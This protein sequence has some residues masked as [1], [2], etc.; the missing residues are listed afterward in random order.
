MSVIISN[1]K[2]RVT[3]GK[4][5]VYDDK[6]AYI[7]TFKVQVKVW[8]FWITIKEFRELE[9]DDDFKFCRNEAIELYHKIVNPYGKI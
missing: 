6:P 5:G 2:Y 3:I 7:V 8:F 4:C 1:D 9:Y